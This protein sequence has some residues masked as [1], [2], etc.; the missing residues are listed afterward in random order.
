M[1]VILRLLMVALL[2][3]A[4]PALVRA[5]IL[6]G[7]DAMTSTVMQ[8][9][10]SSFSGV[11]LR[12][13]LHSAQIVE[14]FE[15]MPSVEYWRNGSTVQ[16]FDIRTSRTDAT[17]SLDGRFAFHGDAWKPYLGGGFGVH[18]LSTEVR[19]PAL[20]LPHAEHSLIKGGFAA[21]AGASFPLAKRLDNFLELKY[22]H[23]PSYSQLKIN[24]GL[25][26][27]L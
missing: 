8:E 10:Q 1:R 25:A 11:A 7:V 20:G 12:T 9:G 23:I 22:H 14:G 4:L 6:S 15:L 13:R 24:W 18:F 16:P 17:F 2:L 5:G 19:A 21:L 27:Q 26:W 3:A